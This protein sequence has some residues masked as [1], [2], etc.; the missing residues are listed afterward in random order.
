MGGGENDGILIKCIKPNGVPRH[1]LREPLSE[2]EIFGLEFFP[3]RVPAPPSSQGEKKPVAW[4]AT[5]FPRGGPLRPPRP[6]PCSRRAARAGWGWVGCGS[7]R[8]R[9]ALRAAI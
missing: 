5:G 7:A 9:R 4:D 8:L 3:T 1:I 6:A 2:G